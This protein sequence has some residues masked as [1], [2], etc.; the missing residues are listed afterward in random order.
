MNIHSENDFKKAVDLHKEKFISG[1][2]EM[3][4]SGFKT[5]D[6]ARTYA[7]SGATLKQSTFRTFNICEVEVENTAVRHRIVHK[8]SADNQMNAFILKPS[9]MVFQKMV[10]QIDSKMD[11]EAKRLIML[12]VLMSVVPTLLL[13]AAAILIPA[14]MLLLGIVFIPFANLA[15]AAYNGYLAPEEPNQLTLE[16][17]IPRCQHGLDESLA[18]NAPVVS[19]AA[20]RAR[21][22]QPSLRESASASSSA[23]DSQEMQLRKRNI[24][25]N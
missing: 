16:I 12:S 6:E 20:D 5:L 14:P 25:K 7:N 18:P 4:L 2:V 19:P 13:I 23:D 22:N 17:H 11:Q 3:G 1:N 15:Y 24:A 9:Q 10:E 21:D 8:L